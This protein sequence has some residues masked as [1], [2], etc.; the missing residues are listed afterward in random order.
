MSLTDCSLQYWVCEEKTV[1]LFQYLFSL[2]LLKLYK[3]IIINGVT[4][5]TTKL[6]LRPMSSPLYFEIVAKMVTIFIATEK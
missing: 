5:Q 6:C 2:T 1:G 3:H 4:Q